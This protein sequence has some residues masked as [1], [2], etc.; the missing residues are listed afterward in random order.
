M[1]TI[2]YNG[3]SPYDESETECP[4]CH[5]RHTVFLER[6]DGIDTSV[7]RYVCFDCEVSFAEVAEIVC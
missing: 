3:A 5:G 4:Y 1:F 6:E 2:A 7:E